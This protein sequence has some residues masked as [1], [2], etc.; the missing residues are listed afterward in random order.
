MVIIDKLIYGAR[1]LGVSQ[2]FSMGASLKTL[3]RIPKDFVLQKKTAS[4][5]YENSFFDF[6]AGFYLIHV[7][8]SIDKWRWLN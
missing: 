4:K 5:L 1:K 2:A 3:Q 7:E 8:I 6:Q